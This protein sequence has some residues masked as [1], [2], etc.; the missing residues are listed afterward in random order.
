[1]NAKTETKT[2]HNREFNLWCEEAQISNEIMKRI[3]VN[4]IV[5]LQWKKRLQEKL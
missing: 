3:L 1:M 5:Q 4:C 2:W